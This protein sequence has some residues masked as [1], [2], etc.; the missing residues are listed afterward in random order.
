MKLYEM[1]EYFNAPHKSTVVSC[2]TFM[3]NHVVDSLV[4]GR[5][6]VEAGWI[7][8]DL[9]FRWLDSDRTLPIGLDHRDGRH[10]VAQKEAQ[11]SE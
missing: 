11:A 1:E 7:F 10:T 6:A 2:F 5:S 3:S 4:D 9:R 8:P